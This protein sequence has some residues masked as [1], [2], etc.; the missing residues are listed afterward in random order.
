M[1]Q[2]GYIRKLGK[3]IFSVTAIVISHFLIETAKHA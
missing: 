2:Y 1:E 3:E